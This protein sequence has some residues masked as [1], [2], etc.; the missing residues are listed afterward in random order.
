MDEVVGHIRKFA[1]NI[2]SAGHV[3]ERRAEDA[4]RAVNAGDGMAGPAAIFHDDQ[5][6]AVLIA[7]GCHGVGHQCLT[8]RASRQNCDRDRKNDA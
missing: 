2:G 3:I 5:L 6:P 1:G 8:A 4:M 7:A